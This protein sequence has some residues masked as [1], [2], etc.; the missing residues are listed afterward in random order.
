MALIKYAIELE[1][2]GESERPDWMRQVEFV[3]CNCKKC[4]FCLK[5][6][7]TG[8]E[9]KQKKRKIALHFKSG[10]TIRSMK[11]VD[12]A[13][14]LGRG[15][16]YCRMCYRKQ[17][18]ATHD[19]GKKLSGKEKKKISNKSTYGCPQPS[20]QEHI[21]TECWTEGYDKH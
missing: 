13:V 15:S 16:C 4:Y 21:C 7:T 17:L 11:C 9:H 3:P 14:A 6:F 10:E 1:W 12:T 5:G 8:I 19:N 2:D 20:C 18:G